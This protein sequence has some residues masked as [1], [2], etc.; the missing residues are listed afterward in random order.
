MEAD[1]Y[2]RL[3]ASPLKTFIPPWDLERLT[4]EQ[5][6]TLARKAMSYNKLPKDCLMDYVDRRYALRTHALD[7]LG[8]SAKEIDKILEPDLTQ[9]E[10]NDEDDYVIAGTNLPF[11]NPPDLL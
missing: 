1:V 7:M 11:G 2:K 4:D 10:L 9:L 5:L 6:H 3:W 8:Y